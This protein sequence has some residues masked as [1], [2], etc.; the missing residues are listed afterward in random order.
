MRSKCI[1]YLLLL[2]V[3]TTALVSLSIY[4]FLPSSKNNFNYYSRVWAHRGGTPENKLSGLMSSYEKGYRGFEVD[5]VVDDKNI[6]LSHDIKASYDQSEKLNVIKDWK[7]GKSINFWLDLKKISYSNLDILT[8]QLN[9]VFT[10]DELSK[11]VIL[12]SKNPFYLILLNNRGFNVTLW[13]DRGREGILTKIK[14]SLYLKIADLFNFQ[15]ISFDKKNH[16]AID[17]NLDSPINKHIFTIND[18]DQLKKYQSHPSIKAI[19]TDTLP[20]QKY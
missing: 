18:I 4:I 12:E 7:K 6:M 8:T 3:L 2:I 13:L 15:G 1:K 5:I 9:K 16:Q 14:Y 20:P 10:I 17:I 11:S 19:L